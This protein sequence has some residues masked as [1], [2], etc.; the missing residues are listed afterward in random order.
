MMYQIF[1]L[2][3][4]TNIIFSF[5]TKTTNNRDI[6]RKYSLTVKIE[7]LLI[8]KGVL[9]IAIYNKE[10][11]FLITPYVKKKINI[12]EFVGSI[13]FENL[14]EGEYAI[15]IYQDLNENGKLDKLFSIPT[16]PYGL[17]NNSSS[18]PKFN[19]LIINIKK[20]E[21]IKIKIKN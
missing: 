5:N 2:V 17:S 20:N 16:E 19:N 18:F 14:Q 7:G 1:K 10:E 8:K 6:E 3:L 13:T 11:D 21:I 15:T 4:I 12:N 9:Y